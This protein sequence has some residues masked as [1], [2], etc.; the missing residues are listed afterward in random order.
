MK[1]R[2][3]Q[4]WALNWGGLSFPSG[5][6]A[7]NSID[8]T[9]ITV[10]AGTYNVTF[11]R[12]TLAYNFET[13]MSVP[14]V[15][16]FTFNL[17]PNPAKSSFNIASNNSSITKVEVIDLTGKMIYSW[18]GNSNQINISTEGIHKGL[19]LVQVYSGDINGITKLVVK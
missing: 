19:Y 13:V 7:P 3:N 14:N 12:V 16:K 9:A 1:F 10:T 2:P 18:T 5:T 6:A 15:D 11:N 17:Y 8:E 4:S